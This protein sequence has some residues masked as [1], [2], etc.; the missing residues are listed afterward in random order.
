MRSLGGKLRNVMEWSIDGDC[1]VISVRILVCL[2]SLLNVPTNGVG[3]TRNRKVHANAE[4][5]D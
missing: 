4:E 5:Y 3:N 2:L 1:R